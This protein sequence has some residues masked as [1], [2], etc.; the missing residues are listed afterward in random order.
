MMPAVPM[1]P[2]MPGPMVAHTARAV[3]GPDDAAAAVRIVG[4]AGVIW[5]VG[6]IVVGA[7]EMAV[8][9]VEVGPVGEVV[10]IAAMVDAAPVK[11]RSAVETAA[12]EAAAVKPTSVNATAMKG[13]ATTVESDAA[14][15][16]GRRGMKPAAV[17]TASMETT[18]METTATVNG[19]SA[20][21]VEASTAVKAAASSAA[22]TMV[23]ELNR[24]HV[25]VGRG[26]QLH[27][28]AHKRQR[29]G[30]TIGH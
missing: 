9:V 18:S 2:P 11:G 27:A 4:V 24:L 7:V 25:S 8:M 6:W 16:K 28:G 12:M 1:M 15:L 17:K 10:L 13:G 3:I 20:T 14:P 30:R 21:A 26:T 5:I 29:L 19:R 22:A 23:T